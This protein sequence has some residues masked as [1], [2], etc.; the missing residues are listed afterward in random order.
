MDESKQ[1]YQP[2]QSLTTFLETHPAPVYIGFG[3]LV[4][5][6]PEVRSSTLPDSCPSLKFCPLSFS[7]SD[8]RP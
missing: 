7:M 8:P 1:E 4:V 5:S 2:H 6:N 3:S